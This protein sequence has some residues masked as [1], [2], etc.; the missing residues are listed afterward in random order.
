M[1][2]AGKKH[3]P[4]V[5]KFDSPNGKS[6]NIYTLEKMREI[7][8][9]ESG[10]PLVRE[11][12]KNIVLHYKIPSMNY[13]DEAM[14]IGDYVKRKVRYIRDANGI[15][16]IHSPVT[17]IKQI[18]EGRAQGDCDDMALLIATLLLSIGHSPKFRT[19][20]YKSQNKRD[21]Y[22]HVYVVTYEKNPIHKKPKRLSLDAI[23]KHK[24]IGFE[25]P[26]MSGDEW[27]V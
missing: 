26:H 6:G 24:P 9:R 12:A 4:K 1:L 27:P 3:I 16:Q 5:S 7:A 22:N 13:Y 25:I 19:V 10:H 2:L 17:M 23:I 8:R 21:P 20:R 14:A 11:L 15:E 18:Q